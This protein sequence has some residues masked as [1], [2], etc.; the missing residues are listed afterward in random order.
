MKNVQNKNRNYELL[1]NIIEMSDND[2]IKDL[3]NIVNENNIKNK[4]NLILDITEKSK[5]LDNDEITLIYKVNKND[6]TIKIFD[7]HFVENNK[8]VCK[9]IYNKKVLEVKEY[10][11]IKNEKE[12]LIIKLKGINNITN[13]SKMFYECK[14]LESI[15]DIINF[16]LSRIIEMNEM[17]KGCYEGLIIPDRFFKN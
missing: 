4:I 16:D 11:D 1:N 12:K 15:P 10:I 13:A 9:I 3:K 14:A 17:F 6:K 2:V 7:A 5:I 8:N